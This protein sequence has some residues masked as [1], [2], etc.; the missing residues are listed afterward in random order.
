MRIF[1]EGEAIDGEASIASLAKRYGLTK[2]D[3]RDVLHVFEH[4]AELHPSDFPNFGPVAELY[5]SLTSSSVEGTLLRHNRT[6][7]ARAVRPPVD[8]LTMSVAKMS[9][10]SFGDH[11]LRSESGLIQ[12]NKENPP[13]I[14]ETYRVVAEAFDRSEKAHAVQQVCMWDLAT[15]LVTA[16]LYHGEEFCP[17]QVAHEQGLHFD[18]IMEIERLGWWCYNKLDR[19][20]ALDFNAAREILSNKRLSDDDKIVCINAAESSKMNRADA[21]RLTRYVRFHGTEDVPH[22][23]KS[24]LKERQPIN[25]HPDRDHRWTGLFKK[26]DAYYSV[27]WKCRGLHNAPHQCEFYF[28]CST[29]EVYHGNKLVRPA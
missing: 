26:G 29:G 3:V 10:D 14:F 23:S 28:N 9:A 1:H 13:D 5:S 20:P 19:V 8:D 7:E 24:E 15:L 25:G 21:R 16:R 17:T 2:Q 22:L 11:F 27:E 6:V 4:G 12:I 18:K